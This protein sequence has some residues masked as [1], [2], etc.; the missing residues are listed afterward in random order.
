[1][2][3]NEKIKMDKIGGEYG[4]VV[5]NYLEENTV[6]EMCFNRSQQEVT[7]LKASFLPFPTGSVRPVGYIISS[8]FGRLQEQKI[9]IIA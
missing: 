8:I 1:M 2:N 6:V 5:H 9:A 7:L 4:P 3:R